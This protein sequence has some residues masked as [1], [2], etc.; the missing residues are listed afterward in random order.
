[1]ALPYVDASTS[2]VTCNQYD[3]TSGGIDVIK[4]TFTALD[5]AQNGIY[6]SYYVNP[7]GGVINL[8]KINGWVDFNGHIYILVA[9]SIFMEV[10]VIPI[11]LIRLTPLLLCLVVPSI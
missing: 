3:W 7:G 9:S 6:G 10:Q 4:G 5:L 2:E 1:M 11:G 8:E